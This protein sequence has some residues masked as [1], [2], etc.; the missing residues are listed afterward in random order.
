M[1]MAISYDCFPVSIPIALI[2]LISALCFTAAL[3]GMV[4]ALLR[5][6]KLYRYCFSENRPHQRRLE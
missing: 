4:Y 1:D 5:V 6:H 2:M 3:G